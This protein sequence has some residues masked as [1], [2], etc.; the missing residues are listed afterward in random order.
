MKCI[1]ESKTRSTFL[2][3]DSFIFDT[4]RDRETDSHHNLNI[5]H[6]NSKPLF[7]SPVNK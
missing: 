2:A 5:I 6:C 4:E 7:G 1:E 3:S